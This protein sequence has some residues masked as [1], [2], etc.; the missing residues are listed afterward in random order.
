MTQMGNLNTVDFIILIL[1]VLFGIQGAFKGFIEELA[2]KF[3][4]VF[5]FLFAL[6]FCQ[7]VCS[8][9]FSGVS[10]P[11]WLSSGISYTVLFMTGYLMIKGVSSL[12][13]GVTDSDAVTFLDSFMGF[14]LGV[15]EMTIICG[16]LIM[17]LGHQKLVN[18]SS[19]FDG[20]L[21]N[22]RIVN[23]LFQTLV[24]IAHKVI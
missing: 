6:M 18:L 22:S 24:S 3:G 1:V 17:L 9:L 11:L 13:K 20:S 7:S 15:I 14:V 2:Q 21:L 10:V 23:P 5:G 12:I 16:A 8:L 4:F 19:S